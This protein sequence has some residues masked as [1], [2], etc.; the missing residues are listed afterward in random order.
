L[1]PDASM[2][3]VCTS[4]LFIWTVVHDTMWHIASDIS[5]KN[6]VDTILMPSGGA[7]TAQS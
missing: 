6:E 5:I 2:G 4:V 1:A 3:E 7:F